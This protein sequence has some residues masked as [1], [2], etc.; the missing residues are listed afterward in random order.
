MLS[1]LLKRDAARAISL[2]LPQEVQAQLRARIPERSDEIEITGDWEGPAEV[3]IADDF[4]SGASQAMILLA[5]DSQKIPVFFAKGA[6]RLK[7]GDRLKVHGIRLGR[8]IG[9]E[10]AAI[11]PTA[12][13]SSCAPT[14]DQKVA[15]VL[16]NFG[17]TAVL[18]E[19]ITPSYISP[20]VFGTSGRSVDGFWRE[21]SYGK[22]S[23]SGVVVGPYTVASNLSCDN[24]F[25]I[26]DAAIAAADRDVDFSVYN[27][28]FV[29]MPRVGGSCHL[30]LS[31]VGCTGFSSPSKGYIQGPIS[32]LSADG[33]GANDAGVQL[34]AHE[35]GHGLGLWH[36]S[37]L[38]FGTQ[39]LGALT[40]TGVHD[41]YGDRFSDMGIGLYYAGYYNG[42][43]AAA[44]KSMLGWFGPGNV[45]EVSSPGTFVL[46][47]Y[48]SK[49]SGLQALH[50]RR[51]LTGTNWLWIEYRQPIGYD[52]SFQPYGTQPYNGALI[53]YDD[54][55]YQGYT[56][57]LAFNLLAPGN[58]T[59]PA[60][61]PG[62]LWKDPYSE[63]SLTVNSATSDGLS[64][65]VGYEGVLPSCSIS[66]ASNPAGR[67]VQLDGTSYTAPQT[68]GVPCGS[69]HTIATTATQS[70]AN[71]I[72]YVWSNW[73]DAG[74]NSHTVIAPAS[75]SGSY[76]A[77]FATRYFLTIN[78]AA[79]GTT[80]PSSG[81][82]NAGQGV[83][84]SATPNA[85]FSFTGWTGSGTGSISGIANPT[86]ITM[87]GPIAEA[88]NFSGTTGAGLQFVPVAP[89]R[90]MD[91]R[92][93]DG[94]LGG[95]F[96][97]AN[98]IR[99]IPIH[100]SSCGVPSSAT[101]YS[102][103]VTAVPRAG[104]LGYLTIWPTGQ[105]QPFVST[106]NSIDGSVL[107]NGAI[108]A[109]GT[110]GSVNT[111][112]TNDVDL[113]ADINGY[114]TAPATGTLQYFSLAPC[115]VLDTR[116]ANGTFGGPS[117]SWNS[118]SFPIL[119]SGCG[120]PATARAYALNVTAVP[121]GPL[122]YLTA[123]PTGQSQPNASTINSADG[124]ILAN[125]AIVPAGSNGSV[126]FYGAGATD[127][128][129]DIN[130]Y[131][132]PPAPGGL[133]F[134]PVNACRLVDTR[135]ANGPLGGPIIGANQSRSF[136][137]ASSNCGLPSSASAYSLNVTAVPTGYLAYVT[138]WPAGQTQPYVSTLNDTKGIALANGALIPTG[139][140]GAIS[141][142][143][144]NTSHV[145]IDTNGYFSQ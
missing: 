76:T 30:G 111:F 21:A 115:R 61:Q 120:V 16:V 27:H 81:W 10:T 114:F 117:L 93:P 54:P 82:Y 8:V 71:G 19:Y 52:T 28:V 41:E 142:Y 3:L 11:T 144:T 107:A 96:I 43:Y 22:T 53:H 121:N 57:L 31:T 88:A 91:T 78:A 119:S 58:F 140:G 15:V 5:I 4:D 36:A 75:G 56:S 23:A 7:C 113:V 29:L 73:S 26:S 95:P 72:Q 97:T 90:A 68:I 85:G 132:A 94:P 40:A 45:Q 118:R 104:Y 127:L 32:W 126:S 42:H 62:T 92:S 138:T 13:A 89:C 84:I 12:A 14:G 66:L 55:R 51:G 134:Y 87:N 133:N 99:T 25:A 80:T 112:A 106:L 9:A 67:A 109:A 102:L 145:V 124:T 110:D 100:S 116:Q 123:W 141:V 136:T 63:L 74:A 20:M 33:F 122:W 35:G 83:Q 77:T 50:I 37:T 18:P 70:G 86:T 131:F 38:G 17:S 143:V 44:H 47:P 2:A 105:A 65:T 46:E 49:T 98:T 128:V 60:L 39:P 130:G 108:V 1:D 79:G 69:S 34:I 24:M 64:V 129:V 137:P 48:E 139:T 103:N 6:P 125:A 135:N 59:Q 101:A